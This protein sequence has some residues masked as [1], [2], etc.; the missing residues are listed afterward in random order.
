[1]EG[2]IALSHGWVLGLC[3]KWDPEAMPLV[4]KSGSEALGLALKKVQ[5]N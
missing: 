3:P 5:R 1:L 2:A 4:R